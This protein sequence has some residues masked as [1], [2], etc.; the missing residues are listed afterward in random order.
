MENRFTGNA[1]REES[2]EK[3]KKKKNKH[4]IPVNTADLKDDK[5]TYYK[6]NGV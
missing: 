6:K 2:K 3:A 4:S 1:R 5:N